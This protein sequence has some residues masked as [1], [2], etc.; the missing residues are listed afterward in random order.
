MLVAI[1]GIVEFAALTDHVI[2]QN[3]ARMFAA[4]QLLLII[5]DRLRRR[6]A[7][8][9][10]R[11]HPLDLRGLFF[12]ACCEFRDGRFVGVGVGVGIGAQFDVKLATKVRF[13][14][15]VKV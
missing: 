8:F 10:L 13:V 9:K 4:H 12:Q 6:F 11:A 14:V 3:V 2:A 15:A 7:H 1:V 5:E